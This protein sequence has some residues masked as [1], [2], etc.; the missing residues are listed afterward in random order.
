MNADKFTEKTLKLISASVDLAREHGHIQLSPIHIA[1]ALFSDSDN[2]LKMIIQKAGGDPTV[3]ERTFKR[4]LSKL[5]SQSP[6]PEPTLSPQAL[7]VIQEA[8]KIQK[9]NGDS[10]VSI[11]VLIRA[12]AKQKAISD[13]L[14]D[15][16]CYY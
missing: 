10:H 4:L 1:C 5:P 3:P 6:P 11:D 12:L 14:L 2:F 7:Q 9:E 16:G 13:A 15:A 8:Q